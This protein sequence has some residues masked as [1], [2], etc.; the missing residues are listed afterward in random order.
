MPG[1]IGAAQPSYPHGR[2]FVRR[3]PALSSPRLS[4]FENFSAACHQ[5]EITLDT[6]SVPALSVYEQYPCIVTRTPVIKSLL[7]SGP[8]RQDGNLGRGW[9]QAPFSPDRV[10]F[11]QKVKG[12][13][14]G[15]QCGRGARG[16]KSRRSRNE[17]RSPTHAARKLVEIAEIMLIVLVDTVQQQVQRRYIPVYSG[18]CQQ[19]NLAGL[20]FVGSSLSISPICLR[21]IRGFSSFS[22]KEVAELGCVYKMLG[23]KFCSH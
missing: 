21:L 5:A 18:I 16:V 19:G 6:S 1:N 4:E 20:S 2:R 15:R 7:K 12:Q 3:T 11:L 22:W 23:Q 14:R 9:Q 17:K 10:H 8:E 13:L